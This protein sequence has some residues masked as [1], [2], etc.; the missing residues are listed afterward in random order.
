MEVTRLN[1]SFTIIHGTAAEFSGDPELVRGLENLY[2]LVFQKDKSYVQEM[3]KWHS[4]FP[5]RTDYFLGQSDGHAVSFNYYLT[6]PNVNNNPYSLSG[7]SL[8]H[9]QSQ[10]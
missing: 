8:S 1:E 6:A 2:S 7:G 9:P 5:F 10:G 4:C 3:L